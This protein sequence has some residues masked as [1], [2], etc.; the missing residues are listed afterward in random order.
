VS[1]DAI[2]SL[3]RAIK[4][5]AR[6]KAH[7]RLLYATDASMYQVEPL[8]V[9]L[10]RD[11]ED[12]AATIAWCGRHGLPVLPRGGGTSLA[13]QTVNR[14]VVIDCS[15]GLRGIG[16]IQ[17]DAHCV[18]VEP[19]VVLD[20]L[21][22][23]ASAHGLM[24]GPEVSTSTHA[25]LGGMISNRSA[26]LHSLYWGMTDAH[27]LGVDVVLADGS[28]V[29]FNRGAA[30]RD[31]RVAA[32]TRAVLDVVSPLAELIDARYPK[33][34]RNVG[35]YALDRILAD[36][37]AAPEDPLSEIDLSGLMTGSEG[38]L[39]FIT[40][41]DLALVPKP[42]HVGLVVLAFPSVHHALVSLTDV[43]STRPAAVE[44]LDGTVLGAARAHHDY[45]SLVDL[46]PDQDANAVLYID[47]FA[48]TNEDLRERIE[49]CRSLV[50]DAPM[51]VCLDP[52]SQ[53]PLW[54]LRKIG[55]GL[56]LSG[57]DGLHPV[58]GLEDCA[59]PPASLAEFQKSF[60]AMLARH[61]CHATYYA[62]ASVGLLHIRPRIDLRGQKG[63]TLLE[64]LAGEA[65]DLVKSFGG[66]VSG[67]HG[68]GRI[69]AAMTHAFYGPELVEAFGRIKAIFDPDNR[70]NPGM[71][72]VDSGM[73]SNLRLDRGVEAQADQCE[74]HF[75]WPGG[76][77]AAA[78]A[79]NGNGYCRRTTGGAMCPSYRA[80]MDERHATRGR[81][82]GLRLAL[83][84]Q[85]GRGEAP[86]WGDADVLASLD[87]CLGCKACRHE[88]PATVDVASLKSEYLAQ[89]MGRWVPL[90]TRL[91]G[92]V[93]GVNR[94]GSAMHPL[95]T[96]LTRRGPVAALLKW[97]LGV[98]QRRTLPGFSRSLRSWHR[99]R[100][101]GEAA[102]PVV[103]LYPDCFS[104]WTES[105]IGRDAICL[106]EAFG[107][108][109]VIPTVG[110]CGRTLVSSG[111][112]RQ[113][114][115]VI[116]ASADALHAAIRE[117]GAVAVLGIE[118][119]C[120]TALQEEWVELR[121]DVNQASP[122]EIAS[123]AWTIEE[124]IVANWDAHPCRPTFEHRTDAVAL[125]QHCHQKHRGEFAV[126]FL[127]RCGWSAATLH[128]TGCCGMAGSF[129]Y[130]RDHDEISRHIARDSL[131]SVASHSGPIAANGTSCR[132]QMAD[133]MDR[134]AQHPI[135]LAA[136]ALCPE[137]GE[138]I[139]SH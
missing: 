21:Q 44:L 119:S 3:R 137:D 40:G 70:F 90:R 69:R 74:T 41:A 121:L 37:R 23:A 32:I 107:Y 83:S 105:E 18:H 39:A 138:W 13:G 62:H 123:M 125:H 136:K 135:S 77:L 134:C 84:G 52:A 89:S 120:V 96:M 59:V 1:K 131:A 30:E 47:W 114:R 78:E 129:G 49:H 65:T 111:M 9:V 24:F 55:L 5:E 126:S 94:L 99:R 67:E 80:T 31:A 53:E 38:T 102:S 26:G 110:C 75:K 58:G 98:S 15:Q 29:T 11:I 19:G 127:H 42:A 2:L 104:T 124:F 46:L 45:R 81:A 82:N 25:T 64:T 92:Y 12:V 79:C 73:T 43:L 109:V 117:T 61:G 93:R 14:A 72:T 56:I 6:F 63:R 50:P 85:L 91:L 139:D 132:H 54:R 118:P 116:A 101:V 8:G 66:T 4:G 20:D 95:S 106:L 68:D 35:G 27:V 34:R 100:P 115:R 128:D 76:V 16:P 60:E 36:M 103:L 88:C 33:T 17:A 51:R 57:E 7:D 48:E 71:V 10:P 122:S 28:Q 87:L 112:L 108:R 113:A 22:R 130:T 86:S 97:V 133:V